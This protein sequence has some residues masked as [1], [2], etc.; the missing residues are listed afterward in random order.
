MNYIILLHFK[1]TFNTIFCLGS[2]EERGLI[3]WRA[4]NEKVDSKLVDKNLIYNFPC[5]FF[6]QK[7]SKNVLITSNQSVVI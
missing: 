5:K 3:N 2:L 4:Q 6:K 1:N 7:F